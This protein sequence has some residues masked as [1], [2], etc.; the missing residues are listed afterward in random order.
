MVAYR[1]RLLAAV[2]CLFLPFLV[3]VP[4]EAATPQRTPSDAVVA[5]WGAKKSGCGCL[6]TIIVFF[7]LWN[8]L[9]NFRIFQ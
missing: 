3:A 5:G 1:G 9:G 6:G 7:I 4:A 2:L 8:L